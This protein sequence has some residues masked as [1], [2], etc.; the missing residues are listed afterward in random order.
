MGKDVSVLEARTY[1]LKILANAFYGYLGFFGA[2]WYC[3]ECAASTTA[4]T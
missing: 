2:R 1:A 3:L 4:S